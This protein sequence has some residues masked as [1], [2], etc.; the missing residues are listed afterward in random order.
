MEN[1]YS[2]Q[3]RNVDISDRII[4]PTGKILA[5]QDLYKTYESGDNIFYVPL[6]ENETKFMDLSKKLEGMGIKTNGS[7]KFLDIPDLL[8]YKGIIC[9]PY[10]WSTIMFFE[11][12]Q[13]GMIYFIPSI[14]FL[15]EMVKSND[16]LMQKYWFQIPYK[17]DVNVLKCAEWYCDE[18]S[19]LV[20]YYDSWEE[21][22]VKVRTT[23]YEEQTKKILE[24]A[25]E[26][27]NTTI[28]LWKNIMDDYIHSSTR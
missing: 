21:L 18:H 1:L 27:T 24:Y 14:R 26:H 11:V 10:A 25:K 2:K 16:F 17:E 13:L 12:M 19:N 15:F 22:A 4:K 8:K 3:I 7:N 9:L 20:I 6:Y 23:N 28:G 5:Y